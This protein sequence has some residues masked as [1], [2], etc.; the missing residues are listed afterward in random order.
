MILDSGE[1]TQ[2]ESGAVRD[3]KD[4]NGRCDLLPLGVVNDLMHMDNGLY[5]VS[6]SLGFIEQF[7]LTLDEKFLFQAM[8]GFIQDYYK[9]DKTQAMLEVSVHYAEGAKKYGEWNWQKGIPLE[10]FIDS[11][12]RHLL[13]KF[14]GMTDESHDRAFLWNCLCAIWTLRNRP[15]L[16]RKLDYD[17]GYVSTSSSEDKE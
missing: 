17:V 14:K 12:V 16:C 10:S 4:E 3:I 15:E 1:R 6:Q 13:K 9:G 8:L 11:A 5:H 2:F 7:Q